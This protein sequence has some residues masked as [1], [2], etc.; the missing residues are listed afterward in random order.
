MERLFYARRPFRYDAE[1]DLDQGQCLNLRGYL[2]DEKLV[3]LGYVAEFMRGERPVQCGRCGAHFK[4]DAALN[5]HGFRRHRP[6]ASAPLDPAMQ[7]KIRAQEEARLAVTAPLYVDKS[8]AERD[9]AEAA[10]RKRGRPR[11]HA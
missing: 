7:D 11:I 10:R 6:G 8:T 1:L 4:D 5:N 9:P 2:N 3:R